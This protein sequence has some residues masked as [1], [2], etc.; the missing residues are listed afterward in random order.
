MIQV[1]ATLIGNMLNVDVAL[2][3]NENQQ[4]INRA[5]IEHQ[6]SVY[7]ASTELQQSFNRASTERQQSWVMHL[8]YSN[9]CDTVFTH[10]QHIGTLYGQK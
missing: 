10:T 4:S 9:G 2:P 8:V 7:R 3:D 5:S 6:Q 1:L